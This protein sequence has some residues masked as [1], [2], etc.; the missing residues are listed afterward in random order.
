M[1]VGE[2]GQ[3]TSLLPFAHLRSTLLF[4]TPSL[5]LEPNM[6]GHPS[7]P[8]SQAPPCGTPT[9]HLC[10]SLG[11]LAH[12]ALPPFLPAHTQ[13]I[14]RTLAFLA[15]GSNMLAGLAWFEVPCGWAN[16]PAANLG[17]G[18]PYFHALF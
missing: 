10:T 16:N 13:D 8:G 1:Q 17:Y 11:R 9:T 5:A 14:P 6:P 7:D 2:G 18:E 3:F 4:V 15:S 12:P